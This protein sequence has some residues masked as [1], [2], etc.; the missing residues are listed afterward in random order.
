MHGT[1]LYTELKQISRICFS[2]HKQNCCR[3]VTEQ[4]RGERE[5]ERDKKEAERESLTRR[6]ARGQ[7]LAP[8]ALTGLYIH[9]R[10]GGF[11]VVRTYEWPL[12]G[13]ARRRE[14]QREAHA[15]RKTKTRSPSNPRIA[16]FGDALCEGPLVQ[17]T[18]GIEVTEAVPAMYGTGVRQ[19]HARMRARG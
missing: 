13:D 17:K 10:R 7:R 11:Y 15:L 18:S 1:P 12:E 3:T 5:R 9:R 4:G 2:N 6:Q 14:R 16:R 19:C 8:S